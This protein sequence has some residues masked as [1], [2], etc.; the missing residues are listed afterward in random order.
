MA[1]F[2]KRPKRTDFWRIPPMVGEPETLRQGGIIAV[3]EGDGPMMMRTGWALWQTAG[4]EQFQ[5]SD[6]LKDG[7]DAWKERDAAPYPE[8]LSFLRDLFDTLAGQPSPVVPLDIYDAPRQRIELASAYFGTRAW[9]GSR[10]WGEAEAA[11]DSDTM[12]Q[13]RRPIYDALVSSHRDFVPPRSMVVADTL[14]LQLGLP[15]PFE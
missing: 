4:I 11:S 9:T 13:Y 1:P 15:S 14:A 5:A 6:F 2:W 12:T 3:T 7:Y 8:R 10:L